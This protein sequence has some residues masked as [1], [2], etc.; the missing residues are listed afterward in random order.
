MNV[1]DLFSLDGDAAIVTGGGRGLGR[2]MALGLA[3]AGADVVV[4]GRTQETLDS[5]R[6]EIEK[7]GRRALAVRT[8]VARMADLDNLVQ[9]AL[10]TFGKIDVLVNNAGTTYRAPSEEYPEA[11]WDRVMDINVKSVFF[12]TQKVARV[13]IRQGGG[14]IIN[15]ASLL[16]AIGVPTV[17][18]YQASKA[19][20]ALLTKELAVEW[21]PHNIRVNAIG[22]GYF[23]TDMTA[24]L[25]DHPV[26]GPK[27]MSRIPMQ[28]WGA[29]DQLKGAVVFLASRASDYVTGQVIYVDGG[30]L[31]G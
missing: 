10:E 20:V 4:A 5:A 24:P 22:P 18:A 28:R 8:D 19:G 31:A 27:I 12:L 14:R 11:E 21:A 30:W 25:K 2:A 13:M 1:C 6:A 17:P 23:L 29:P 9:A 26:R 7:L 16:S 15:M 3:E